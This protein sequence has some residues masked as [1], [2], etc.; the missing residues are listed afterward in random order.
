M[1]Y[2][3]ESMDVDNAERDGLAE[4]ARLREE[5]KALREILKRGWLLEMDVSSVFMGDPATC[6]YRFR[7]TNESSVMPPSWYETG[8]D[9][10][11][12]AAVAAVK[13]EQGGDQHSNEPRS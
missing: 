7:H 12:D 8:P 11:I 5:N 6:R 10:A 9:A 4:I 1:N 2:S 13:G 3:P